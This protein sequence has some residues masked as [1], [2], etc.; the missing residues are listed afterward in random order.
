MAVPV[1]IATYMRSGSSV[2]GDIVQQARGAFYVYEPMRLYER[3]FYSNKTADRI[4]TRNN[5]SRR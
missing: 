4:L 5:G 1:V 2:V 3:A